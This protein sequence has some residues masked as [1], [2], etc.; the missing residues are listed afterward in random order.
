[1]EIKSYPTSRYQVLLTNLVLCITITS[2]VH[3]A[4][5][6]VDQADQQRLAKLGLSDHSDSYIKDVHAELDANDPDKGLDL[7]LELTLNGSNV[8]LVHFIHH[9]EQL[10]ASANVLRHIGFLLPPST[11]TPLS[12]SDI[13]GL[14]IDYNARLQTLTLIAPI[15]AL[16]IEPA[17]YRT[18]RPKHSTAHT[19][20]GVLLNYSLYGTYGDDSTHSLNAYTEMRAFNQLGVLKNTAIT[21]AQSHAQ[22]GWDH[23]TVRLDTSWRQSFP[24]SLLSIQAGDMLTSALSWTRPTRLGG[25]QIGSNFALQPYKTTTPLPSFFGKATLPSAVELYVNGLK[26][27]DTNV[28]AGPFELT[29]VPSFEGAGMAQLVVTDA[30]GQ[31]QTLDFPLYNTHRLLQAG[32]SDWSFEVGAVRKDYGI[33]SFHY[34]KDIAASGTWRYGLNNRFTAETHI[35]ATKNLKNAGLGGTWLLGRTGGV[36]FASLAGSQDIDADGMQY[37]ANYSWSNRRLNVGIGVTGTQGNYR[38]IAAKYG[39]TP[40]HRSEQISAGYNTQY[41]GSFGIGYNKVTY[42]Q[43]D[44]I[45]L[46]RAYWS[47]N[48]GQRIRLIAN[49]NHDFHN[50]N[51]SSVLIGASIS[52]GQQRA[53]S[54]S[55]Q[56]QGQQ[57]LLV[58]DM[59]QAAPNTGG[60]GWR[61]Q[62][63][64]S[65]DRH[66]ILA[67]LDHLGRY[68]RLKAGITVS[69]DHHSLYGGAS[70][71]LVM[72][73]GGLFASKSINSSFA[74][75]STS[76]VADV[77]ILLQNSPIGRTNDKGLLLLS[78]LNAYQ[79]NKISIDPMDLPANM[80]IDQVSM[81]ATPAE[82]VGMMVNIDMTP[83]NAASVILQDGTGKHLPLGSQ[84]KVISNKTVNNVDTLDAVVGFDGEVYLDILAEKNVLHVTTPDGNT[85]QVRFDYQ[86]QD[87]NIPLIGPI[88]CEKEQP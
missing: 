37:S 82:Q 88:T 13:P 78:P 9:D 30:L 83:V 41:A 59:V 79:D 2:S 7:Y 40:I 66:D 44:S 23:R 57:S 56:Q 25:L 62:S 69:E 73:G 65:A 49:L 24:D 48:I 35:E 53:A 85:C 52:L 50:A 31:N 58:A 19:S 46:A 75:V 84:V 32:L 1:M 61:A 81:T 38:D 80:R 6:L 51:N 10:W 11:V 34:A 76:G 17:V 29:T 67:E 64:Y 8:G 20:P 28:P 86:N 43:Q 12:L 87:N 47:K 42:D 55:L 26:Q 71:A 14:S 3:A 77:P 33:E 60:M 54:S 36:L 5:P 68:G 74:V 16:D 72:M 21:A 63:R 22:D 4:D 39:S 15:D 70:G 45:K 27:F 18:Y